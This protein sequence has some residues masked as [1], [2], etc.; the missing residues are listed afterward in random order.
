MKKNGRT[1]KQDFFII[2]R[3]LKEFEQM[4]PK[5]MLHVLIR[6][7][8]IA[9]I[10]FI[11][12]AV[13]ASMIDLLMGTPDKMVLAAICLLGVSLVFLLSLW[14]SYE[15]CKIAV[16]YSRLFP[17]HEICLTNKAYHLPYEL[18]E[19]GSTGKLR[20][21]V[22]GSIQLSGA[23]MA[24][25][26]WDMDVLLT[27]SVT[28]MISFLLFADFI[29]RI[30]L[31][32]L[33]ANSV[34]VNAVGMIGLIAVLVFGCSYIS[35][36]M[37]SKRFDVNFEVFQ[38]GSKHSRYGEFYTMDYL[39]DENAA[40]DARIYNQ[41]KLIIRECQ[42]NCYEHFAEGK[43]KELNAVNRY[44]G[45]KLVS[46]CICGCIV[47]V[48]IGQKALQ[49]AIGCGSIIL[50]YAAATGTIN[51]LSRVAEI[52]TDLRNNNEHL[53][54]YFRYMDLPEDQEKA[55]E[56]V[57]IEKTQEYVQ[58][59]IVFQNVSFQ[60]PE[61][62]TPVLNH[63]NLVI[64]AG[65]KL[66]IVGENGSGKTTLIKLLCRLYKPTEGQIL[67]NGKDIWSYPYAE[68]IA[69]ISTVF[70]DF[71]LLAFSLAENV[72]V[73]QEYDTEQVCAALGKAGLTSRVNKL[74]KGIA[75]YLF[76]DFDEDGTDLS[77]GEA[78]K[79]AIARAIYKD[80]DVMILDEPTAALDPY[81]EYEIYKNFGE[82][83]T[84]K[85]ILSISHRLSSCR[86]CD[87]IMVMC[88]GRIV[89]CGKHEELLQDTNGKYFELWNAQAQYYS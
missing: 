23:G 14:Q 60:Y 52:I 87:R 53:L 66:A 36:K 82:I 19:K 45:I 12:T 70:Q 59:S 61:S 44:D 41:E 27:N 72:A 58:E 13:S 78:Q 69:G 29:Y 49:G 80:A 32:D 34:S 20:D 54:R 17:T 35:C 46:S 65:E 26:Y 84:G 11:T 83:A 6:S 2:L 1:L 25:L 48:L 10:P 9:G 40:M 50:L 42:S 18:L 86:M 73:S 33:V 79:V 81:A 67:L 21:E 51:A 37:T 22:S 39:S 88:Q 57:E 8:L 31:W 75:Q 85:T 28:M 43:Q 68:Y 4:L 47:Y 64:K 38:N 56:G 63:I 15:E 5:Q 77:G 7:I 71:T 24:S 16:G 74:E 55:A 30:V 62:N 3:G 76:H 89:Q